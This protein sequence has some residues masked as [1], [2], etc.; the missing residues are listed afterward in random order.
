ML[1][2]LHKLPPTTQLE[3]SAQETVAVWGLYNLI[4]QKLYLSK[5]HEIN[6]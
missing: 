1:L 6:S 5:G 2:N 3:F 4:R